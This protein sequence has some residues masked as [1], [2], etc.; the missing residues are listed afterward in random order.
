MLI[1]LLADLLHTVQGQYPKV[2]H[3]LALFDNF[4]RQYLRPLVYIYLP[5][6]LILELDSQVV[7]VPELT[8]LRPLHF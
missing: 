6:S 2:M 5:N 8:A 1:R 4:E 7:R 3:I